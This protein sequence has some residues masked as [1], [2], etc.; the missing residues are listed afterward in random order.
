MPPGSDALADLELLLFGMDG[1]NVP[2]DLVARNFWQTS[3]ET[4]VLDNDI[5]ARGDKSIDFTRVYKLL[6]FHTRRMLEL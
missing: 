6:T 1:D 4:L 3:S 2:D 5:T